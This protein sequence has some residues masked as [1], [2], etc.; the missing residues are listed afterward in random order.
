[1]AIFNSYLSLPEGTYIY[2]YTYGNSGQHLVIYD[3]IWLYMIIYDYIYTYMIIYDYIYIHMIIY[4]Y[5]WLYIY[6]VY[7][8]GDIL[9]NPL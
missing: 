1:M 3:Y 9:D 7:I 5:I 4:D 2:I 8:N 6:M